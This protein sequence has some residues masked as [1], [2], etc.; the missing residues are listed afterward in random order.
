M[1]AKIELSEKDLEAALQA[2]LLVQISE[3]GRENI[4]AQAIDY[5]IRPNDQYGKKEAPL[6]RAFYQAAE[7]VVSEVIREELKE[8]D[9]RFRQKIKEFVVEGVEEWLDASVKDQHG[10]GLSSKIAAAIN[11]AITPE[12]R[13]Y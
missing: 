6:M 13:Y 4:I 5:L 3:I 2:A 10:S 1:D 7:H 9:S 11:K 8:P 12:G